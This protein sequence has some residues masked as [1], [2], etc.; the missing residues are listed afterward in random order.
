[1]ERKEKGLLRMW[2]LRTLTSALIPPSKADDQEEVSW[3][4]V[5]TRAQRYEQMPEIEDFVLET[6]HPER[7]P[8]HQDPKLGPGPKEKRPYGSSKSTP[9]LAIAR[10]WDTPEVG[11][12]N[13]GIIVADATSGEEVHCLCG[14]GKEN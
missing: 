9:S 14:P 8:A 7:L 1:M 10:V 11:A 13:Y 5:N 6:E 2:N 3:P 4:E 12:L